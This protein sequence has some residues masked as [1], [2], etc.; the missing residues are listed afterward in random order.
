MENQKC[1]DRNNRLKWNRKLFHSMQ[2]NSDIV[3]HDE[4]KL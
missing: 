4:E 1:W 3:N 2:Q